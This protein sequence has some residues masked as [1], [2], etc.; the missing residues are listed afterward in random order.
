MP[1]AFFRHPRSDSS[2]YRFWR[3]AEKTISARVSGLS[4]GVDPFRALAAEERSSRGPDAELLQMDIAG[5]SSEYPDRALTDRDS[6]GARSE[7]NL[8]RDLAPRRVDSLER[9]RLP[10]C[11]FPSPDR[12]LVYL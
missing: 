11:S 6:G 2:G 5:L 4:D 7:V 12:R 8:L 1:F 9:I 10:N 3:R